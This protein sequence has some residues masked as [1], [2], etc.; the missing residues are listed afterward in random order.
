MFL[1]TPVIKCESLDKKCLESVMFSCQVLNCCAA[2]G[3]IFG[4]CT[5]I[6]TAEAKAFILPLCN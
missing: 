3:H 5:R 6:S 4:F 2:V 1:R